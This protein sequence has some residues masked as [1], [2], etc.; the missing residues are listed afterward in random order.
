MSQV[1]KTHAP[2]KYRSVAAAERSAERILWVGVKTCFLMPLEH[3]WTPNHQNRSPERSTAATERNFS[4][5]RA[6][7][8]ISKGIYSPCFR[9]G[10]TLSLQ[11]ERILIRASWTTKLAWGVDYTYTKIWPR[12]N[13]FT[14]RF[15]RIEPFSLWTFLLKTPIFWCAVRKE[16]IWSIFSIFLPS[17]AVKSTNSHCTASFW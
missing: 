9:L 7:L 8:C 16:L 17:T 12:G 6:S 11:L 10:E 4:L 5:A 13:L 15:D 1:F 3:D 2:V 14:F